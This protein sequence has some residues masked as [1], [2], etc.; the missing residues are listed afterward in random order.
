MSSQEDVDAPPG[1]TKPPSPPP[2]V[3]QLRQPPP[4]PAKAAAPKKK[5]RPARRQVKKEDAAA[6]RSSS[7][8]APLG[9]DY[10]IWYHRHIGYEYRES[11]KDR[12]TLT[13]CVAARDAGRTRADEETAPLCIHFAMGDCAKGPECAFRHRLPAPADERR[14]GLTHDVFGRE[15]FKTDRDDMGGVGSYSR[16]NRTLYVAGLQPDKPPRE[17][18]E[19]LRR[20]FG[21]W[22][23]LEY[24]R[25][26]PARG[27]GFVRYRLRTAA[28]FAK[29]AMADQALDDGETL[30]VRWARVD[31][32]PVAQAADQQASTARFVRAVEAAAAAMTPQERA[33]KA[34]L[35]Q[36]ASLAEAPD[37]YP[38]TDAQYPA[39][40]GGIGPLGP[41]PAK[42]KETTPETAS[43]PTVAY[44][45]EFAGAGPRRE[46]T[47]RQQPGQ[48]P[49]SVDEG[50]GAAEVRPSPHEEAAAASA[51]RKRFWEHYQPNPD[52]G[53]FH[54]YAYG[55][56]YPRQAIERPEE[57]PEE[58]QRRLQA[59]EQHVESLY[60]GAD[61]TTPAEVAHSAEPEV[62]RPV[63][64]A[65]D[66]PGFHN[67]EPLF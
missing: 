43:Q 41:P 16:E 12:G 39:P 17:Y 11:R 64:T 42:R 49:P 6:S 54:P 5:D 45:F 47:D 50:G 34:A 30:N 28:E 18:E 4:Q 44:R 37:A 32:N 57:T 61:Y 24:V 22:G 10:N 55:F 60:A 58:R 27:I 35:R 66:E 15:R 19:A 25:V 36:A 20:H 8:S 9:G 13:R 14:A 53:E 31:P 51:S 65:H 63:D 62:A 67:D 33:E 23:E 2:G 46:N 29:V 52:T 40:P 3:T 56:F 26:L 38:D 59:I 21:E 48:L 7:S 1:L